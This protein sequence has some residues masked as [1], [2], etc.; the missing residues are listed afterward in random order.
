MK[1]LATLLRPLADAALRRQV[2]DLRTELDAEKRKVAVCE[3]EIEALA[4]VC[5]HDCA[6]IRAEMAFAMRQRADCEGV[7]HERRAEQSV[8]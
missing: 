8:R 5:A 6:R 7:P 3:I 2:L 1:T 4:S